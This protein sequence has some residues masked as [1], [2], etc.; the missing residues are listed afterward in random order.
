MIRLSGEREKAQTR[1]FMTWRRI[2]E[3]Q[4]TDR[5]VQEQ[6][7][8]PENSLRDRNI[9]TVSRNFLKSGRDIV[10]HQI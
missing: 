9:H 1:K 10:E 8:E 3:T 4:R 5:Q 7:M 2:V 6:N